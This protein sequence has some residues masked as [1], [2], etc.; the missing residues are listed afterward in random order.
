L[1]CF[2]YCSDHEEQ[3]DVEGG[4]AVEPADGGDGHGQRADGESADGGD[5]HGQPADGDVSIQ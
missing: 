2:I 5:A 1:F 4:S 3:A